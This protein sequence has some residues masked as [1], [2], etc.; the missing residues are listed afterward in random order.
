[1]SGRVEDASCR[2]QTRRCRAGHMKL[3]VD[4]KLEAR[5]GEIPREWYSN[6]LRVGRTRSAC[7]L[8]D[9][10]G[11]KSVAVRLRANAAEPR[12]WANEASGDLRR[13]HRGN[14]HRCRC[15]GSCRRWNYGNCLR[16]RKARNDIRCY[17]TAS[18]SDSSV[19]SGHRC[20]CSRRTE[21]SD[22]RC[23]HRTPG[24]YDNSAEIRRF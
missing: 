9:A 13:L 24:C 22:T 17:P 5:L 4:S 23:R 8:A 7:P 1:M 14:H 2:F 21:R 15:Y 3:L 19:W 16:W 18:W 10:R 6:W 12:P 11:Y 20:Y